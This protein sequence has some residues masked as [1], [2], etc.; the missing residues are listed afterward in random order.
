V[1]APIFALGYAA[2]PA[3]GPNPQV[4]KLSTPAPGEGPA[5]WRVP[6]S[7]YM[8]APASAFGAASHEVGMSDGRQIG[9]MM[10]PQVPCPVQHPGSWVPST[11]TLGQ[12]VSLTAG[13]VQAVV[14]CSMRVSALRVPHL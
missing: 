1:V 5:K 12:R 9:P 14:I 8:P 11:A 2:S 7:L 13:G 6:L 4:C 10:E 3:R